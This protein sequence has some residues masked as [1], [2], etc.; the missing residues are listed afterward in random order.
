MHRIFTTSVASVYPLYVAK[1]ERK[2][3]TRAELDEVITW[4]TGFDREQLAHHLEA[5]TTFE[6]FFAAARL[7]PLAAQITGSVCG[8]KV[9]EVEDPL[10][11]R[12]R[13]LDKLVDELARGKALD[14]VLRT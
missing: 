11:R 4:L 8:V 2:G 12:I 5:G 14:R 9:Q 10:M 3:R 13:Y 6:D 7:N 1:L